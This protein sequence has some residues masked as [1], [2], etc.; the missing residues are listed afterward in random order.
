[1]E[2]S[3]VTN[4]LFKAMETVVEAKIGRLNTTNSRTGVVY[5]DP[6]GFQVKV[7]VNNQILECSL[8]EHLHDWISKDD[9]VTISDLYGNGQSLVVTGSIGSTRSE[10]LVINDESKNRLVGGV[11]KIED[12]TGLNDGEF[13]LE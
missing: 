4:Q 2:S 12:D 8:P 5:E 1:L 7:Q 10:S 13:A 9:V 3:D 6:Q 11:H